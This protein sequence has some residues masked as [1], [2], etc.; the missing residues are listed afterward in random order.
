MTATKVTSATSMGNSTGIFTLARES[1]SS[2]ACDA[3]QPFSLS[4]GVCSSWQV[5]ADQNENRKINQIFLFFSGRGRSKLFRSY[6]VLKYMNS[7][8]N[9]YTARRRD[10]AS[11]GLG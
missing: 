1:I 7:Y 2:L 10:C 4:F 11:T 5:P 3:L 9:S 8:M 6:K